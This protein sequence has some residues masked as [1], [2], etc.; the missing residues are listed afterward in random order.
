MEES[1]DLIAQGKLNYVD[2]LN[3]FFNNLDKSIDALHKEDNNS[4]KCPICGSPMKLRKGRYGNF[5][6]CSQW[7]NC[8]GM[9][10]QDGSEIKTK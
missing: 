6:G 2:F 3:E 5:F 8:N 9:R 4:V 1:L 7:P 10:R